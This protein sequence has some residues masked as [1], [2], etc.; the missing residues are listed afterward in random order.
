MYAVD[1]RSGG[2]LVLALKEAL[3][4]CHFEQSAEAAIV[5][6]PKTFHNE[7]GWQMRHTFQY[8]HKPI[9]IVLTYPMS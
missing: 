6:R 7:T 3:S 5:S 8:K 4:R 2:P 1:V 9:R